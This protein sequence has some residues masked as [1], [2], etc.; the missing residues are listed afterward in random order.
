MSGD[1]GAQHSAWADVLHALGF[2]DVGPDHLAARFAWERHDIDAWV[3]A[4]VDLLRRPWVLPSPGDTRQPS[5]RNG[6]NYCETRLGR[7]AAT[8]SEGVGPRPASGRVGVT[9]GCPGPFRTEPNPVE[10]RRMSFD[11]PASV[12]YFPPSG[13]GLCR[14]PRVGFR[15][16]ALRAL[17][18]KARTSPRRGGI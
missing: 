9:G 3:E 14:T 10:Y 4:V 12:R 7:H 15:P 16:T 18:A 13:P 6:Q 8:R 1:S 17:R 2:A 5:L 11:E